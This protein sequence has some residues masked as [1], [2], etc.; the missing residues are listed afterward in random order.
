MKV[1]PYDPK[2]KTAFLEMNQKWISEMFV[3][4]KEDIAVLEN[5]EESIR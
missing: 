5:F 1:V 4:E 3:L 2:Y